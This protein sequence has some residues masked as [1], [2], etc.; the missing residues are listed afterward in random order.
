MFQMPLQNKLIACPLIPATARILSRGG[1][2]LLLL[3]NE[4]QLLIS[5]PNIV[6]VKVPGIIVENKACW[7]VI[8]VDLF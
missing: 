4:P 5:Y 3:L 7:M 2:Y 6:S 8:V 1:R